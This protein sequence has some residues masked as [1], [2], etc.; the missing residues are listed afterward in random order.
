MKW[1]VGGTDTG[2]VKLYMDEACTTEVGTAATS[3]LTV[4]A[5]GISAGSATVTATSNADSTKSATCDVTV[6]KADPT[7]PT[8]LTATYG[9]TLANVT[10]PD[11]WTWADSTQRVGS[12]VSP[13]AT[14]KANFA[15]NDNYNAASNVDVAVMVSKAANPAAVTGTATVVKGGN[16][17]DLAGN[18]TLNGAT[19]EVTYA[20]DGDANGCTLNGSVLTSGDNTGSV[21]VNVSVAADDN[22][23]ALAATP[24]TVTIS[25]KGTQTITASDVTATFGETGKNVEATTNGNG[26]ISYAVKDGSADY[27]DVDASTGALTIKKA[28]TATVVVTAAETGTYAQA[29]KE[30]TVTISK[31]NAVPATVTA[32]NRTYDGTEKPLVN[33]TGEATGGEMQYALGTTDAAT[34]EYTTSIPTATDAGTYRVYYRY[35]PDSNHNGSFTD[36]VDVQIAKATWPAPDAPTVSSKTSTSVTLVGSE[37]D[38]YE[39]RRGDGDWQNSPVFTGLNVNTEYTFYRRLKDNIYYNASPSSTGANISTEA[40]VHDNIVS[41]SENTITIVCANS[42]GGHYGNTTSYIRINAP[43]LV[44]ENSTGS[45]LATITSDVQ[46]FDANG[47]EITYRSGDSVLDQAP[48]RAGSYTASITAFEHTATVSY[49][50]APPYVTPTPTPLPYAYIQEYPTGLYLPYDG[51]SQ[52]LATAGSVYGGYME[53]ALGSSS[54]TMPVNRWD[55]SV[56]SATEPNT[57]YVWYR[58]EGDFYHRN[59]DSGC[60]TATIYMPEN[61]PTP[62]FTPTPTLTPTPTFTP[63]PSPI[64]EK[65]PSYV[66][67]SP[68]GKDRVYN[69]EAQKLATAGSAGGGTMMYTLGTAGAPDEG[70]SSTV[71]SGIEVGN[72]YIWFKVIGDAFH[73]DSNASCVTAE[74]APAGEE[75]APSGY[76]E[77]VVVDDGI[78]KDITGTAEAPEEENPLEASIDNSA[79]LETLLEVTPEEKDAGVNVWLE[80]IDVSDTMPVEEKEVIEQ[81]LDD[82]TVGVFV[83][84][85]LFKKVGEGEQTKVTGTNGAMKISIVV[86]EELREE[87][88]N[89]AIIRL[90]DGVLTVLEGVY[91][92]VTHFVTFETDQFSSYAV[93]YREDTGIGVKPPKTGQDRD[94]YMW[95]LLCGMALMGMGATG[96]Y[97]KKRNSKRA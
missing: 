11:G 21:T 31:A 15:G 16:T 47:L 1:S 92:P 5:K 17:V 12:V 7:A 77:D 26:A 64:P 19:G 29:T 95:F 25:D 96:Y 56:P 97:F 70:W 67:K 40:H 41:V 82:Y 30:V 36:S 44:E 74:I 34:E 42:D 24:I 85:S 28:G 60:V 55:S 51:T 4:Y 2:A 75:A 57:Y 49:R 8:G 59:G 94:G 93:I 88:R 62:T 33:V 10:L 6:N 53:Y 27:I 89:Y 84:V 91:D 54:G 48:Y 9:Q 80:V 79:E 68:A 86:P 87:G 45:A 72:Y 52:L 46:G 83:D 50:I 20:L 58:A 81:A 37:S 38:N 14:F 35:V 32:N 22:Y 73:L 43:T 23:N 3:T 90:H 39:Y 63:T 65:L 78:V 71:P 61:M 76:Y 66:V 13:A 18:V 69:G